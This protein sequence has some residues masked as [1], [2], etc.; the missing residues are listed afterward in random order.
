MDD[1]LKLTDAEQISFA[2]LLSLVKGPIDLQCEYK[3]WRGEIGTRK[4]RVIEFWYGSTEWHPEPCLLLKAL[5][6]DKNE[7]RDFKMA[8]FDTTTLRVI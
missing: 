2:N 3:N 6:L 1:A 8:D 5:D 7:E 4:L